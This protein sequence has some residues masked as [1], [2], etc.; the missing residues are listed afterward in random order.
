MTPEGDADAD[1]LF[2]AAV[3]VVP[4]SVEDEDEAFALSVEVALAAV[5]EEIAVVEPA[6]AVVA[7][8]VEEVVCE[9][10]VEVGS[11]V[12]T[13]DFSI[14]TRGSPFGPEMG[15]SVIVQ[16]SVSVPEDLCREQMISPSAFTRNS[17]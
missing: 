3:V 2:A 11:R 9:P 8:A 4:L 14:R 16:T 6:D 10:A 7:C 1:E 15:V 13:Q 5:S 12:T 17:L